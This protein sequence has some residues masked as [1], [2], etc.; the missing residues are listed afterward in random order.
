MCRWLPL[1]GSH[2]DAGPVSGGDITGPYLL[3]RRVAGSATGF[4]AFPGEVVAVERWT[5]TRVSSAN[6]NV[7]V[8]GHHVSVTPPKV[9]ADTMARKAVWIRT[10]DSEFEMAVPE[11]T[12][13][14]TGHRVHAVASTVVGRQAGQRSALVNHDTGRWNQVDRFP[15]GGCYGAW[16]DFVMGFGQGTGNFGMGVTLLYAVPGAI[17]FGLV[18]AS[19]AGLLLGFAVGWVIGFCHALLGAM[20]ARDAVHQQKQ[21]VRKACLQVFGDASGPAAK[22]AVKG[23]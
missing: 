8:S 13:V 2:P 20:Q 7:L 1:P 18:G 5:E 14:R 10:A 4:C 16:T 9:W 21:A 23:A 15:T 12:P 6:G 3:T 11:G 17:L 19:W 22:R